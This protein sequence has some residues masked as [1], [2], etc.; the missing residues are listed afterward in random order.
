MKLLP[1]LYELINA[2]T[3]LLVNAIRI[4]KSAVQ[5]IEIVVPRS[6][7]D[8][9]GKEKKV[10]SKRMLFLCNYCFVM[11]LHN[12]IHFLSLLLQFK[13]LHIWTTESLKYNITKVVWNRA[14]TPRYSLTLKKLFCLKSVFLH[15]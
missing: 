15:A 3:N 7:S 10:D 8:S 14:C 5:A 12:K 11:C 1:L 6:I 4:E 2:I 13:M 9:F